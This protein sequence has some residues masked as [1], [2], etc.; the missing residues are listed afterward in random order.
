[1]ANNGLRRDIAAHL[2]D[3]Q[4]MASNGYPEALLARALH[5]L[6]GPVA[7]T[8][9]PQATTVGDVSPVGTGVVNTPE[10]LDGEIMRDVDPADEC[11]ALVASPDATGHP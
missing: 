4:V 11:V 6:G 1:M 9:P 8:R 2:N 5:A 7:D 3:P 10:V